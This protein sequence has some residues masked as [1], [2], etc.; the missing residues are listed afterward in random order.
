MTQVV[1]ELVF[2]YRPELLKQ[3]YAVLKKENYSFL[4][5]IPSRNDR[6]GLAMDPGNISSLLVHGRPRL[7]APS[8]APGA[9]QRLL[10]KSQATLFRAC[11][12]NDWLPRN[13]VAGVFGNE[14]VRAAI[15]NHILT[16]DGNWL[17]F[18]LSFV[19]LGQRVFLR[20]VYY[21]YE[22]PSNHPGLV[23]MGADTVTFLL[24]LTEFLTRENRFESAIEIGSG[25]GAALIAASGFVKNAL[26]IDYNERA[27]AFTRLNAELNGAGNVT[28]ILSDMW[29]N[30]EGTFDLVVANPWYCDLVTGGLEEVPGLVEGFDRYLRDRGVCV[31]VLESYITPAGDSM[32]DFLSDFARKEGFDVELSAVGYGVINTPE[33][34]TLQISR[35]VSYNTILRK[36]GSGRVTVRQI[37]LFRRLKELA[38]LRL[39]RMVAAS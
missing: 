25:S 4:Q 8:A 38:L 22:V 30:V 29:R 24:F 36:G 13:E 32:R 23:W 6:L 28:A 37:P 35:T 27:V 26:G 5:W 7:F 39:R 15:Q 31:M 20:D 17:R 21:A 33:A 3:I 19:P 14:T 16:E 10:T 11:F 1:P 9:Y 34:A 12:L 18:T 2:Q